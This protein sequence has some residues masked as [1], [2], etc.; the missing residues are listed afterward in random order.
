MSGRRGYGSNKS[1]RWRSERGRNK[2]EWWVKRE[3]T[4]GGLSFFC[5]FFPSLQA[6]SVLDRLEY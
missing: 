1:E 5:V 3:L 4:G 6:A 2:A